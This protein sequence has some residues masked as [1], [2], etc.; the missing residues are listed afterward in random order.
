MSLN[1]LPLEAGTRTPRGIV[2]LGGVAVATWRE[3]TVDNNSFFGADTFKVSFALSALDEEHSADWFSNQK[4]IEIE[5]LAGFPIDPANPQPSEMVSL[6]VGHVDDIDVD[7]AARTLKLAGR[8]LSAQLI[9]NKT[10]PEAYKNQTAS[11]IA[12]QLAAKYGLTPIVTATTEHV[13]TYWDQDHV[14]IHDQRSEYDVLSYLASQEG[15]VLIIKGRSLYFGISPFLETPK[16][17]YVLDWDTSTGR[18]NFTGKQLSFTRALT[19]AKGVTVTATSFQTKHK[20]AITASYPK[21]S[22]GI[23]A[24]RATSVGGATQNHKI[25]LG[26]NKSVLEVEKAAHK[27]YDDIVAHEM[28][29]SVTLLGDHYLDVQKAIKVQGTGTAFDQVYFPDSIIRTMNLDSSYMMEVRA[30]NSAPE[31]EPNL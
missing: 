5:I 26:P 8:D 28:K 16:E 29:L 19:I 10:A 7:L 21:G 2:K 20:H 15:F 1:P 27:R 3:W 30:K 11:D 17:F 9:D 18:P 6:I 22:K 14:G 4:S 24:G 12:N 23:A 31:N 13:G 25:R